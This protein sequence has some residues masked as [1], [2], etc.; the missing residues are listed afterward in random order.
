MINKI[1]RITDSAQIKLQ[2]PLQR[3]LAERKNEFDQILKT[4][5]LKPQKFVVVVGPCSA[6]NTEAMKE[7]LKQLKVI[8]DRVKKKILIVARIYTSKPHSDG[9]GYKGIAF[10]ENRFDQVN[11]NSG[12]VNAR[13]LMLYCLEIGLPIAD[14]LLY[15]E[16]YFY[17]DDLVSYWFLG[18]RSGCDPLHRDIASGVNTLVGIKNPTDGSLNQTILSVF[19]VNNPKVFMCAGYQTETSGNQYAHIV[20][21]GYSQGNCYIGNYGRDTTESAVKLCLQRKLYPYIIVDASHGNSGKVATRQ[22]DVVI[23]VLKDKNVNGVMIES[24]LK[25]GSADDEYGVSKTDD[26]MDISTTEQL[27]D[28]I[29][30]TLK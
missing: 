23:D 28:I 1:E 24:Y 27:I 2:Y 20:L 26:C 18:A 29:Y 16:H 25:S 30:S 5:F 10:H 17:F 14:E 6:D 15:P 3:K 13:Q 4:N 7:Y 9:S 21:R 12:L 8:A 11:F 22:K 19:A